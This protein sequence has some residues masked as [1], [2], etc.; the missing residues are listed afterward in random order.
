WIADKKLETFTEHW[1]ALIL[2]F[3]GGWALSAAAMILNDYFDI[4]IDRINQPQRPLPSGEI[5]PKTALIVGIVLIIIGLLMGLGID[6]YEYYLKGSV[7]G[8]ALIT[9]VVNSALLLSYTK[10]LKRYSLLGNFGVS[11][12]VWFGFMYGDLIFDF[13]FDWFP[14]TLGFAAFMLN[15]A[16]EIM[17]GIMD[18]EGDRENNVTTVATAL[19]KRWTAVVSALFYLMAV[20]STTIPIFLAQATWIY[21]GSIL[22]A[23]LMAI[24]CSVWILIDQSDRSVKIVKTIVLYTMLAALV[25]FTLEAL[26]SGLVNPIIA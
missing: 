8:V 6:L 4:E 19:G 14:E 7:F 3:I 24:T 25:S 9:A 21:A 10:I 23:V 11:I 13:S 26:L 12:G 15:F 1:P 18:I 22:V 17:K 2:T 16:R 5:K 20:G